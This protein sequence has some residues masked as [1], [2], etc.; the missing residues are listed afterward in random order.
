MDAAVIIHDKATNRVV[1]LQRSENATFGQAI[2]EIADG[3]RTA[4]LPRRRLAGIAGRLVKSPSAP[5]EVMAS[6]AR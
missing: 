6:W 4:S 5:C 2:T 1:L 3:R